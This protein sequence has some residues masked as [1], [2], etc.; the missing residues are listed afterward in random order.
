MSQGKHSG[1]APDLEARAADPST[2]QSELHGLAAN[3]PDL[4][5]IIAENPTTYPELVEWLRGLNDRQI[6]AALARRESGVTEHS[7]AADQPTRPVLSDQ[8]AQ[9]THA[10][11]TGGAESAL[12][13]HEPTEEF[14][15]VQQPYRHPEPAAQ[16]EP[17]AHPQQSDFDQRLYGSPVAAA[18]PAYTQQ[19]SAEHPPYP[20][21][22]QAAYVPA[23]PIYAEPTGPR[24][25]RR[26]GGCTMVFLL[27]LITLGALAASYF[28]L[29]GNPFDGEDE[30]APAQGQEE[31]D[32]GQPEN[33]QQELEQAED[34]EDEEVEDL[35]RPAP[36]GALG[37]SS[38]SAP[39]DNIHCALG[40]DE[41]NCTIDEYFFD[42]PSGCE[43]TVTLR[44]SRDGTAE[45]A[46]DESLSSQQQNLDY[47]Q[48]TGN[49]DFACEATE[50]YFECW[51]Q[52]TGNGFQLAREYYSLYDD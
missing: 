20:G 38:F 10:L 8:Q 36:E 30:G 9:Q 40:G 13:P 17:G 7:A 4:R 45:T 33:A 6:N 46:C 21:Y 1:D 41:V 16:P 34:A 31:P 11:P 49:D 2:S 42:T 32:Q 47:G 25:R 28:L 24:R 3:H 12:T 23:A 43:D 19:P 26:G 15:A 35:Q 48:A 14:G 22:Q 51:S 44:V 39:S 52:H 27:A 37:I 50:Q 18:E 5:A 29:F